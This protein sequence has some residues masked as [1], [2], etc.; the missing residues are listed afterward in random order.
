LSVSDRGIALSTGAGR[1]EFHTGRRSN[2]RTTWWRRR[3]VT[4]TRSTP[5][6][7][8]T[9]QL[10]K[11]IYWWNHETNKKRSETSNLHQGHCCH[12]ANT[13]NLG[14]ITV[15][16]TRSHPPVQKLHLEISRSGNRHRDPASES[17]HR[18]N[19]EALGDFAHIRKIS[20]KSVRK[21]LK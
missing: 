11:T 5:S 7:F 8:H 9:L 17:D 4:R 1:W 10:M 18:Q 20:R 16:F 2:V 14:L 6:A 13:T 3:L 15:L 12:L 21:L 19:L